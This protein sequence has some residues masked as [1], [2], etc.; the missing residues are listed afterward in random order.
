M[1]SGLITQKVGMSRI[2][3]KDGT[4]IP[5]TVLK[6]DN[7]Q[8]VAHRCENTDGYNAIQLGYGKAK[9]KH[10]S[11]PMRHHF[12]KKN[13]GLKKKLAE[14]RIS[15]NQSIDIGKYIS[16]DHFVIGQYVD[17]TGTSIGKGFAGP[18]KRHN[19][20]VYV[21]LT[22]CLYHIELMVLPDNVKIQV[23]YSRVRK[24]QDI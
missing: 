3:Q 20:E 23:E 5:V 18:M 6:I 12:K 17:V 2:F 7:L 11:K 14:F 21:L 15:K 19:F 24:W 13:V 9:D 4:H 8:V 22:E 16:A 10:I 1:R